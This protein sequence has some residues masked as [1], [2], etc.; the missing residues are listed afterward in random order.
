MSGMKLE[1][2]NCLP[3]N[4]KTKLPARKQKNKGHKIERIHKFVFMH[5][6]GDSKI[7]RRY[8]SLGGGVI[9]VEASHQP[10]TVTTF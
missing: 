6:P 2:Q 8:P 9:V 1:K 7:N 10:A 3:E 4:E 5:G